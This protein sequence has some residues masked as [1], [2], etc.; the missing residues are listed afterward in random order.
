LDAIYASVIIPTLNESDNIEE[1]VVKINQGLDSGGI[2]HETIVVD[3]DSSDGTPTIVNKLSKKNP[4]NRLISRNRKEGFGSAIFDGFIKSKGD[5]IVTMDADFSHPPESIISLIKAVGDDDVVVGSRYIDGGKMNGPLYRKLLSQIINRVIILILDLKIHDCTGGFIALKRE[6]F[7][8]IGEIKAKSGDF[9]FEIIYKAK[10][11][12]FKIIEI[13]FVYEW[14]R[15]GKT[16][17]NVL[18]F[19]YNYLKSAISLKWHS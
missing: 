3:D 4:R 5:V 18:K 1:L 7:N 10:K 8:S 14:R 19:G 15:K 11:A 9:S 6:V 16:K 13:P 2:R 12:G 17:T